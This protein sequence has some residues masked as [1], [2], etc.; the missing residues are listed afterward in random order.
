MDSNGNTAK[1]YLGHECLSMTD[2]RFINV[3]L[4]VHSM[5]K[6]NCHAL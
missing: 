6:D 5:L 2:W 1:P 3:L 4:K